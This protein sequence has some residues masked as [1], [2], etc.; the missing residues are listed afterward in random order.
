MTWG[1]AL[2]TSD[3]PQRESWHVGGELSY[4]ECCPSRNT[5][6]ENCDGSF[7]RRSGN[8]GTEAVITLNPER[9]RQELLLPLYLLSN[10]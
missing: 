8:V 2:S 4:L 5:V 10:G 3:I 9:D 1:L 7:W 6:R